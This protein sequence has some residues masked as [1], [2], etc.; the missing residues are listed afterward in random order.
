M[1]NSIVPD[2][3]S[4]R[5]VERI[6]SANAKLSLYNFREIWQ[7][8]H[9]LRH[10]VIRDLKSRY[11]QTVLGILW[12]MVNPFI[13]MVLFTFVFGQ[14]AN[15][16]TYNVPY[17]VFSFAALVPWTFFARCLTVIPGSLL[18]NSSLI[19]KIYFP[20]ILLPLTALITSVVDFVIAFLMLIILMAI[21]H[22]PLSSNAILWIPFY[23]LL[24]TMTCLGLGL[25]LAA[26]NVHLRDIGYLLPFLLQAFQFLSPIAY[27][28]N[29]L[30]EP[31]QT[32]ARL[33]PL[34]SICDGYR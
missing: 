29:L 16:P 25:V 11:K 21:F 5:F 24:L 33:N 30:H 23:T 8:R 2:G 10:L 34:V 4:D 32:L 6:N 26:L 15:V 17:P 12:S 20:R 27:S 14:L 31:L 19:T 18:A 13:T 7:Y 1:A 22:V 3:A 28:S 9:M